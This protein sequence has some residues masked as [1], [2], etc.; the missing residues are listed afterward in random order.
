MYRIGAKSEVQTIFYDF[1]VKRFIGTIIV[2]LREQS[3]RVRNV[4]RCVQ[5]TYEF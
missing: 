4:P 5:N 2:A 1:S 3:P